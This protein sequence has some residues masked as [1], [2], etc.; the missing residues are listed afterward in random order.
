MFGA[1]D[2]SHINGPGIKAPLIVRDWYTFSLKEVCFGV[3]G[4]SNPIFVGG[5]AIADTGTSLIAGPS[6]VINKINEEIIGTYRLHNNFN[7]GF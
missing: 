7:A 3:N 4:C 1:I 6:N 5:I 2:Q